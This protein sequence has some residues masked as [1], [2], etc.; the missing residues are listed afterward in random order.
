[1]DRQDLAHG[2]GQRVGLGVGRVGDGE[3]EPAEVVV[4]VVVAVPAAGVLLQVEGEDR[5]VG[6]LDRLLGDEDRLAR[7]VATAGAGVDAPGRPLLAVEGE[8][9]RAGHPTLVAAVVVDRL[10][11][12]LGWVD[13]GRGPGDLDLLRLPRR[14]GRGRLDLELRQGAGPLD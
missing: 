7:L 1:G 8:R 9:H 4:L 10:Q 2:P 13:V 3:P 14:V 6:V 12:R 5:A 11:G